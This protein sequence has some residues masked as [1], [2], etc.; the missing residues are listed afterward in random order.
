MHKQT[1]VLLPQRA[2]RECQCQGAHPRH[3]PSANAS[4]VMQLFLRFRKERVHSTVGRE[5]GNAIGPRLD[6]W[7]GRRVWRSLSEDL[8]ERLGSEGHLDNPANLEH[9]PSLLIAS[10]TKEPITSTYFEKI[11]EY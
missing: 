7:R 10:G 6:H 2:N 3:A 11:L 4:V 5:A 8:L 1:R 9:L